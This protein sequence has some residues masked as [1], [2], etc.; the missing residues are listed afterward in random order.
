MLEH[1]VLHCLIKSEYTVKI[2]YK[3][4]DSQFVNYIPH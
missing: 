2:Y 3:K 4:C 1:V